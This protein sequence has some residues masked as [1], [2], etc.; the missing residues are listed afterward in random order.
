MPAPV[1]TICEAGS[2]TSTATEYDA[3]NPIEFLNVDKGI[4]SAVLTIDIWNDRDGL[5]GSDLAVAPQLYTVDDD[6]LSAVWA[7]TAT[8]GFQSMLEARSCGA[9]GAAADMQTDWT[10]ISPTDLLILGDIPAGAKRLIEI[11]LNPP[12]DA[13]TVA[14]SDFFLRVSA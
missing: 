13:P 9:V 12:V 6:D 4:P 3:G 10:P 2:D 14:L 5:A 7:G 11:R 1:L 8:N